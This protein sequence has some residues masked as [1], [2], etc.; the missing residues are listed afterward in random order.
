MFA[1]AIDSMTLGVESGYRWHGYDRGPGPALTGDVSFA[2]AGFSTNRRANERN[3]LTFDLL[4]WV[5]PT[6]RSTRRVFDQYAASLGYARC[7][8]QCDQNTWGRRTTLTL[9]GNGYWLPN[10]AVDEWSPTLELTLRHYVDLQRIGTRQL[11]ANLSPFVSVERGF[12]AYDG[13]YARAGVGTYVG[14]MGSLA[15]SL[16][17]SIAFS[18]WRAR[19][20]AARGFGY[21]AGDVTLGI[22][23]DRRLGRRRHLS[24]RLM[25]GAEF[26][27]ESIGA[28]TGIVG[29]RFKLSG[30]VLMF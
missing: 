14:P 13:T 22:D 27:D 26:R 16:D 12:N 6:N 3:N 9:A 10:A 8:A 29:L 28:T 5:P 15:F 30:P 25:V 24:T 1:Q 19:T 18:D 7:L 23:H 17:G 2:L 11:G 4:A 20:G 21:H